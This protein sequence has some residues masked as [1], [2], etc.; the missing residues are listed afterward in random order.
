M[1]HDAEDLEF[2]PAPPDKLYTHNRRQLSAMLDGELSPDQA[3]FML[4]RLQHDT[5]LADCWERWQVCGDVLRGQG[6]ALLPADFSRRVAAAIAAPDSE[7][8]AA[9]TSVR[10]GNR[11]RVLRWG[12]GALAASMALVALFMARQLPDSQL[13]AAGVGGDVVAEATTAP[14]GAQQALEGL[15]RMPEAAAR[16]AVPGGDLVAGGGAPASPAPEGSEGA[17]AAATGVAVAELPRRVAERRSRGQSQRAARRVAAA[18][19]PARGIVATAASMAPA[20]EPSA[21]GSAMPL[22]ADAPDA[23]T[24][25]APAG[26]LFGGQP[27]A[28]SRPWPRAVLPGLAAGSQPFSA[29]YGLPS[30]PS[31]AAFAPFQPRLVEPFPAR[32]NAEPGTEAR[33]AQPEPGTG[34]D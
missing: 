4:R 1:N 13:P 6:H 33:D 34:A 29:R 9:H 31:D 12:G 32:P 10:T 8:V 30:A 24:F 17:W 26:A 20:M 28:P 2:E 11:P 22:F 27:V 15:A 16:T 7:S 21:T 3:R 25:G 23:R 19:A 5:E 14:P 18:T